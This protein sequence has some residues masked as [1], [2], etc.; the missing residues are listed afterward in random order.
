MVGVLSPISGG[1]TIDAPIS[2]IILITLVLACITSVTLGLF[3]SAVAGDSD[4]GYLYLS[5]VVVFIV[6]FSGLIRNEKLGQLVDSLSFLST[7]K[8]AFEGFASS[9]GIYCWL[10]SWRFEEFNSTGH[11]ISIWLS[12]G[13]FSL[14]AVSWRC[15]HCGCVTLVA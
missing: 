10:D 2:W 15:W 8:W 9:I 14:I 7:G 4:K 12:L 11:M 5:F 13:A 3:I 1:W 6:L